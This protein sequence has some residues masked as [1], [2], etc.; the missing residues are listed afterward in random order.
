[1]SFHSQK[2]TGF[3]QNIR[4]KILN[5]LSG[6]KT[7]RKRLMEPIQLS[8]EN[9][10]RK[11]QLTKKLRK[12][13]E[14]KQ[15]LQILSGKKA[16]KEAEYR[17]QYKRALEERP[18]GQKKYNRYYKPKITVIL[19]SRPYP[20]I[21]GD[22]R[23][24]AKISKQDLED[25]AGRIEELKGSK[26]ADYDI[27]TGAPADETTPSQFKEKLN[28]VQEELKDGYLRAFSYFYDRLRGVNT[29]AEGYWNTVKYATM[30]EMVKVIDRTRTFLEKN[31][32]KRSGLPEPEQLAYNQERREALS[33][34]L[35]G[36]T[37]A[38]LNEDITKVER[39]KF[40]LPSR[41]DSSIKKIGNN[42][43]KELTR[44]MTLFEGSPRNVD[45]MNDAS[46]GY[47][48]AML[49]YINRPPLKAFNLPFS[50]CLFATSKHLERFS[51]GYQ[52]GCSHFLVLD[53]K[54]AP[55]GEFHEKE[56]LM[57]I[58]LNATHFLKTSFVQDAFKEQAI[59]DMDEDLFKLIQKEAPELIESSKVML[60][61]SSF[62][63]SL[64]Y[65]KLFSEHYMIFTEDALPEELV[66]SYKNP[67]VI[68]EVFSAMKKQRGFLLCDPYT[69]Y[70]TK[71][72][73]PELWS[74]AFGMKFQNRNEPYNIG[75]SVYSFLNDIEKFFVDFYQFAQIL[76]TLE[77]RNNSSFTNTRLLEAS[78]V[79]RQPIN[80]SEFLEFI[81]DNVGE[82][83]EYFKQFLKL[84]K[85]I[86]TYDKP[87][88]NRADVYRFLN[89]FRALPVTIPPSNRPVPSEN[90]AYLYR[91]ENLEREQ[92]N[93]ANGNNRPFVPPEN[94]PRVSERPIALSLRVPVEPRNELT[95]LRSRIQQL[96]N[97]RSTLLRNPMVYN[98]A[99]TTRKNKA[100]VN[101]QYANQ[102]KR[103]GFFS[104]FTKGQQRKQLELN[105]AAAKKAFESLNALNRNIQQLEEQLA[106]RYPRLPESP[107]PRNNIEFPLPARTPPLLPA[108]PGSSAGTAGSSNS[109]ASRPPFPPA[110]GVLGDV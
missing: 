26:E 47:G 35:F 92:R 5:T 110:A 23:K 55:S 62:F 65:S 69:A 106:R 32:P 46:I 27:R 14:E 7:I 72:K 99:S 41:T 12:T 50:I 56:G 45:Y 88:T 3:L 54:Y 21:P 107:V 101:K 93:R 67:L 42:W 6:R 40:A 9:Q 66:V 59:E 38:E 89:K 83:D 73:N 16:P 74:N 78:D 96:K 53:T 1:M 17:E 90:A 22:T 100:A 24:D 52:E 105:R 71:K 75:F 85:N 64:P 98:A 31:Y 87:I 80:S 82:D 28:L 39:L 25:I 34:T 60:G 19:P 79:Y 109:S 86:I 49:G 58:F 94:R 4:K 70:C 11:Q 57:P 104:R 2:G 61:T 68:P 81:R 63:R 102:L 37:E 8:E 13:K 18:E 10:R 97:E 91:Y 44:Y 36:K 15:E 33:Q 30:E 43:G 76:D 48:L 29:D 108:S 51:Q 77:V 20:F 95:Q 84:Q 103:L